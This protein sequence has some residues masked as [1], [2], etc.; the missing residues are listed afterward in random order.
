MTQ[1]FILDENIVILAQKGENSSGDTDPTCLNLF[2]RIIDICHTI[3]LDDSLWNKYKRQL[4]GLGRNEPQGATSLLRILDD[5]V[6]KVEKI[7]YRP[8]N[9]ANF[10][11]ESGIPQGSQD[12]VEIVRLAVETG[13]TLV[14]TD[15]P[16]REDL[17][18]C[19]VQETYNLEVLTPEAA[20]ASL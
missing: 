18:S 1:R 13:V 16:L 19:G 7:D 2:N 17:N 15:A 6:H 11:T 20:L 8:Q 14:T 3:V 12:D 10:P 4:S 5:A 9:A